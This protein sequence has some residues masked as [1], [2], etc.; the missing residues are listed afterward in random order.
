MARKIMDALAKPLILLDQEVC[1]SVSIGI[2]VSPNDGND[3]HSL[4]KNADSAVH[5]AKEQGKNT[6]H[7]YAADINLHSFER[8]A[9]ESSL[10][11]ALERNEMVLYY[12]P[13]IDLKT[14]RIVSAEALLRWKHPDLGLVLPA[15]F[16]ALAEETGLIIP[17]GT[18][19][20]REACR[21]NRA[22]QEAGLLS[23]SV[24]VNLSARQFDDNT[25]YDTIADVLAA[26]D[27]NPTWLELEITESLVMRN[28]EYTIDV[29]ERLHDMGIHLSIDDFG[30]G[31]SSLGY[32]KRFPVDSL[33]VDRSFILDA[34]QDTDDAAITQAIIAMSHSLGLKVVA[35]GV[36]TEEQLEFLRALKCDQVQGYIF[37]EPLL[38]DEFAKL[39]H[40]DMAKRLPTVLYV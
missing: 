40:Q 20:L 10:R 36:E 18:W 28:A 1:I 19:A 16:I 21:Q 4:M 7:F 30:T 35:E 6:F 33:K 38:A 3:F 34:P 37:S 25:L 8:L 29:L 31:Y 5:R 27:L 12:Q 2:S 32:L 23:I 15:Q 26:S 39:L 13:K 9:L 17:I 14:G 24:A 11:R 22:W